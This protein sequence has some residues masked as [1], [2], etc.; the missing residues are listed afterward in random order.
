MPWFQSP[1]NRVKCSDKKT[2]EALKRLQVRFNPLEIGS[3][4]LMARF[5]CASTTTRSFNPLEIGS[6]VLIKG[7]QTCPTFFRKRFN[8]LEIGSSVLMLNYVYNKYR[9]S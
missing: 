5:R 2:R 4:V 6:S 3:S 8:P 9:R 7:G 1:R